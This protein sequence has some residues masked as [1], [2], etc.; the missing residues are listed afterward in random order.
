MR[1]T[2]LPFSGFRTGPRRVYAVDFC[3]GRTLRRDICEQTPVK[4][5]RD[6]WVARLPMPLFARFRLFACSTAMV[7][8]LSGL[9]SLL[10]QDCLFGI[11]A[12]K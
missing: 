9:L 4:A 7:T 2:T 1:V 3:P 11:G 10:C 12:Y 5:I 6:R 8:G